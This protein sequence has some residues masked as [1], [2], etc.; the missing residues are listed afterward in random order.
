MLPSQRKILDVLKQH[1][2]SLDSLSKDTGYSIDGIRGR[3][4]EIRKKEYNI[5]KIDGEYHLHPSKADH[6]QA[7]IDYV[8]RYTLSGTI[9]YIDILSSKL[10]LSSEQIIEGISQ[11]FKR[12]NINVVQLSKDSVTI[13]LK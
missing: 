12:E 11:L 3:I 7:I 1:D 10:K 13:Y 9:L 2:A 4:S 5:E 6:T 8:D